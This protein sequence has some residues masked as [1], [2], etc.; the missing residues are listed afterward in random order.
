MK[1]LWL[2]IDELQL[3]VDIGKKISINEACFIF[4]AEKC[5]SSTTYLEFK[6]WALQQGVKSKLTW[7]AW[8][9]L[10]DGY[11]KNK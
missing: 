3:K 2:K 11:I 1:N 6:T 10:F 9:A 7:H 5:A 8:S 4:W